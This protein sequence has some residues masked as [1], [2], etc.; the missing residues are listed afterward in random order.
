MSFEAPGAFWLFL[1]LPFLLLGLGLWGW[2]TKREI[3]ETFRLNLRRIK[4]DQVAKYGLVALLMAFLVVALA[5]P[6]LAFSSVGT[7]KKSGQIALLVDVSASM[8]A[9]PDPDSPSRLDRA[10]TMLYGIVDSMEA[11]G[12]VKISLHGFTSIARSL[13]PFVGEEE[14]PYLR[15]SIK[16]VLAIQSVPGTGSSLGRPILNIVDKF[17]ESEGVKL[18]VLFSDGEAFLGITRGVQD[19]ERGW[20]DEAIQ[21]AIDKGIQVVT[22][23]IGEA[24]GARVPLY[25]AKG[26]FTGQ[27]QKLQGAD[28]VTYLEEDGL[29]EIA[30]RTGGQ[31][32]A[33]Q[34]QE[35]LLTYIEDHLSPATMADVPEEVIGYRYIAHWFLFAALPL[36]I[37]LARR[38]LLK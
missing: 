29:R 2:V 7:A 3:A 21:K 28:Y 31:Y 27:Y 22:V 11:M 12:E 5:L 1:V 20:M 33:E 6:K 30:P 19:V 24:E 15:E 26:N 32:F 23:G 34:D 9:Q 14:Y 10:R 37:V 36:W 18:I 17:P 8:G 4:R 16:K 13:V 38:Y 25:D 35:E